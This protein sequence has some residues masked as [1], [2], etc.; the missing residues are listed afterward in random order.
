MLVSGKGRC[1]ALRKKRP[2]LRGSMFSEEHSTLRLGAR[3]ASL[4]I[5][6]FGAMGVY[7][8][9]TGNRFNALTRYNAIAHCLLKERARAQYLLRSDARRLAHRFARGAVSAHNLSVPLPEGLCDFLRA[10]ACAPWLVASGP[11]KRARG[12]A[13]GRRDGRPDGRAAGRPGGLASGQA[14]KRAE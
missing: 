3:G 2:S 5:G 14:G 13:S 6:S 8:A 9:D 7:F 1:W 12:R 4:A 11:G 10:L